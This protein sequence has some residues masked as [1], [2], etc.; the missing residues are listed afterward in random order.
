MVE[1]MVLIT[2]H[3][4]TQQQLKQHYIIITSSSLHH[5][6]PSNVVSNLM[7]SLCHLMGNSSSLNINLKSAIRITPV[8]TVQEELKHSQ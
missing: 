1:W 8:N 2:H 7:Y 4:S 5:Y 3:H 6:L